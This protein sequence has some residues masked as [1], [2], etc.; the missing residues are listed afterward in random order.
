MGRKMATNAADAALEA[1]H[2][3]LGIGKR[4]GN[5]D[6]GMRAIADEFVKRL[7]QTSTYEAVELAAG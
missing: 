1:F 4:F 3:E 2:A 6:D 7:R 5:L